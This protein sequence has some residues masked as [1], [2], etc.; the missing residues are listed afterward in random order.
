MESFDM[1]IYTYVKNFHLYYDHIKTFFSWVQ[2]T[3]GDESHY[4]GNKMD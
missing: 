4:K 2:P 1:K 3:W